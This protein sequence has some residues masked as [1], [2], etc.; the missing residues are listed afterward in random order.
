MGA[1]AGREVVQLYLSFP[2]PPRVEVRRLHPG[3][4]PS[5]GGASPLASPPLVLRAFARTALLPAAGG[6]ETLTLNL[7]A[8]D[9]STWQPG[10]GWVVARGNFSLVVGASSRD[11][12]LR[13]E[14]EV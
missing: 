1:R 6:A 10:V 9:L 11:T 14:V 5:E 7:S 8:R 2:H 3:G 13:A 12:R 4:H